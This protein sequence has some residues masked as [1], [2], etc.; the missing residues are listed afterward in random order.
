MHGHANELV[1]SEFQ[2]FMECDSWKTENIT[3]LEYA[4]IQSE[5]CSNIIKN[6]NI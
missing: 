3:L 6:T 4:Q 5:N 2:M 1:L